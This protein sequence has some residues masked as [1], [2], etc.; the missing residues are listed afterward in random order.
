MAGLA[1]ASYTA[2]PM[3]KR[4]T[5]SPTST[6]VPINGANATVNFLQNVSTAVT[7]SRAWLRSLVSRRGTNVAVVA[8]SNKNAQVIWALLAVDPRLLRVPLESL[9]R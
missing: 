4:F 7:T 9:L 8:L 3:K 2:T 6:S 5:M 1:N